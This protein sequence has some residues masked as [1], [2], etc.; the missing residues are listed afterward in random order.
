M[1]RGRGL[2]FGAVLGIKVLGLSSESFVYRG[3]QVISLLIPGAIAAMYRELDNL[4]FGLQPLND[5]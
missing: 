5:A 3:D 4:V 1:L 2:T